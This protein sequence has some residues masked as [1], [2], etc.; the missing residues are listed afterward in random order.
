MR[1]SGCWPSVRR[2][3]GLACA[4]PLLGSGSMRPLTVLS[5]ALSW[6]ILLSFV[7]AACGGAGTGPAPSAA[8]TALNWPTQPI[9][10]IVPF[11]AGGDTDVPMRVL[12]EFLGKKLGP[13]VVVQNVAGGN[14][15]T[16][17]RHAKS[18]KDDA[19]SLGSVHVHTIIN[20]RAG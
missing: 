20:Q 6:P 5:R 15:A 3:S 14:A 2:P 17:T 13:P 19:D 8:A 11:A 9:T 1:C 16:G 18:A 10:L 4:E 7:A 12:A